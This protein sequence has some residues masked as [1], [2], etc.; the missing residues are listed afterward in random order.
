M[1]KDR[2]DPIYLKV[3]KNVE[4]RQG[5]IFYG[6]PKYS[7]FSHLEVPEVGSTSVS[8][9]EE[10][11][12]PEAAVNIDWGEEANHFGR[13]SKKFSTLL[14]I[15]PAIGIVLTQDCDALRRD[16]ITLLELNQ[17]EWETKSKKEFIELIEKA[18]QAKQDGKNPPKKVGKYVRGLRTEFEIPSRM[19]LP[20]DN[21]G[22][23]P[24]N[25]Y[26]DFHSVLYV[27]RPELK[28]MKKSFR[29]LR[30]NHV[31]L[32]HF[33][34]KLNAFF[35]RYA[36]DLHYVMNQDE[37]EMYKYVYTKEGRERNLIVP[38]AHQRDRDKD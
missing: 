30:L 1:S 15:R 38:F 13:R 20:K 29:L 36:S 24:K 34:H 11:R 37:Y 18:K 5:D 12:S 17:C 19:Y 26:V 8:R 28:R 33:R 27:D 3:E 14:D 25:M 7:G 32:N 2:I 16:H 6:I 23:F 21:G 10:D 22:F 35:L 9:D 4:I 31:A